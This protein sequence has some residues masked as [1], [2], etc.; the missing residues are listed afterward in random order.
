LFYFLFGFFSGHFRRYLVPAS[1][2]RSLKRIGIS[3]I[4]HLRFYRPGAEEA[5]SYNVLQRLS[6][7][8]VIFV[9]FPLMIWTG[10][11]MSFGFTAAFPLTARLLG[12]HQT[13]R[14][15]HFLVTILLVLFVLVHIFMIFL[16]GFRTRMSAMITGRAAPPEEVNS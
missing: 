13:A 9:L 16:A 1:A 5:W 12:G 8:L 3:M 15:L 11:A 7:L 10:L 4:Q 2:D 6:Y 14:S